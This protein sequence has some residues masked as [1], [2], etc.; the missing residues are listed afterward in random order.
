MATGR[1]VFGKPNQYFIGDK[2]VT[3]DEFNKR[4]PPKP[5]GEVMAANASIWNGFTSEA[6]ACDPSQVEEMNE[7]NRKN[8][9][10]ARYSPDGMCHIPD[11]ADR[12]RLMKLEGYHDKAGGY[13]DG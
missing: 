5:M 6:M 7:R 9:I 4:F 8:G 10:G 11:R 13:G 2:E 12:R 3:E 1:I